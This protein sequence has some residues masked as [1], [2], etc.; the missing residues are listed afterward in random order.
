LTK[1]IVSSIILGARTLTQLE[2]N[3]QSNGLRLSDSE[4][5]E[6]NQL[7]ELEEMYPYRMIDAYGQRS[8]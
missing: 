6:L 3:M 1:D 5:Q 7:S 4:I 2:D 8:F